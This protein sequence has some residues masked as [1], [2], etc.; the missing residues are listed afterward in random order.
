MNIEIHDAALEARIQKQIQSTGS[1]SRANSGVV[2]YITQPG[3]RAT[4]DCIRA[5]RAVAALDLGAR[6]TSDRMAA[7]SFPYCF[8]RRSKFRRSFVQTSV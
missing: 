4:A 8:R 2:A 3:A 1:E 6:P 7:I 5:D